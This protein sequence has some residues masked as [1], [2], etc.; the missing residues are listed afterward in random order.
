MAVPQPTRLAGATVDADHAQRLGL[1]LA[2]ELN[3]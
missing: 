2:G 1:T 3:P